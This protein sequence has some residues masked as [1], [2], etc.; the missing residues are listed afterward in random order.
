MGPPPYVHDL[1]GVG[2]GRWASDAATLL[3]PR[4]DPEMAHQLPA[5]HGLP[6]HPSSSLSP[7]L[8]EPL[9]EEED[10]AV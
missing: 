2:S 8:E 9:A 5:D 6:H 1:H 7:L 3:S 4:R 10:D